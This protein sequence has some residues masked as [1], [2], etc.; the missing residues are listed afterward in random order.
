MALRYPFVAVRGSNVS[1]ES[2]L[3]GCLRAR[4]SAMDAGDES[5]MLRRMFGVGARLPTRAGGNGSR[6]AKR[7]QLCEPAGPG[8]PA[9]RC[10]GLPRPAA[11]PGAGPRWGG[12]GTSCLAKRGSSG[13]GRGASSCS[14]RWRSRSR[15]SAR[16]K[17]AARKRGPRPAPAGRGPRGLASLL[18]PTAPRS[19]RRWGSWGT[20][21]PRP[22]RPGPRRGPRRAPRR[23]RARSSWPGPR[24]ATAGCCRPP[25]PT[26]P[27]R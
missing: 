4:L 19:R 8:G 7:G 26:G 25:R 6:V 20:R 21:R 23:C 11:F 14:G 22:G 2:D 15:A 1:D 9:R 10:P 3:V 24:P 27:R 18:R 12:A 5:P 13:Q 17:G 16:E